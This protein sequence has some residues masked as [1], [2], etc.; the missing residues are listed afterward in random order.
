[1]YRGE[2]VFYGVL[3][4]GVW[5]FGLKDFSFSNT[6]HGRA[7][8]MNQFPLKLN[9]DTETHLDKFK[10]QRS[11]STTKM[12]GGA[13]VFKDETEVELAMQKGDNRVY[14]PKIASEENGS[15]NPQE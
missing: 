9:Q 7:N 11:C 6:A 3:M 15:A 8:R 2:A 12:I 5:R 13:N 14:S 10:T 4:D 1:M